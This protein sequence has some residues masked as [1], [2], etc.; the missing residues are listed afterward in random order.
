MATI[1]VGE[2]SYVSVADAE[3]YASDRGYTFTGDVSV[4]LIQAMDYLDIQDYSGS[5]TEDDQDLDFPRD[6]E[7]EVPDDIVTAQIVAAIQYDNGTDLLG[8]TPRAVKR[9]KTDVIETEYMDNASTTP[10]QKQLNALLAP[11]LASNTL[12]GGGN[13]FEIRLGVH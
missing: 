3:T 12:S 2:N 1:V 5:K 10:V 6:D 8:A 11:Y 4:R 9:K 7:T 13:T